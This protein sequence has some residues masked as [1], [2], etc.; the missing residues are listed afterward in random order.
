VFLLF[1]PMLVSIRVNL[2]FLEPHLFGM[3][4]APKFVNRTTGSFA[5]FICWTE[6]FIRGAPKE[7]MSFLC[8][9]GLSSAKG[10]K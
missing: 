7:I 8:R 2:V 3:R 6:D 4:V 5:S 9:I 1:A 10:S